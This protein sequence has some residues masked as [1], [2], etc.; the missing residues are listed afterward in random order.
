MLDI[1]EVWTYV[2]IGG[3][4]EETGKGNFKKDAT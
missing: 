2:H 3:N 4:I 1:L